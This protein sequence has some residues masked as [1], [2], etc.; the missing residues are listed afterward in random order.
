M[1]P[2]EIATMAKL[3]NVS[4]TVFLNTVF[5]SILETL[6]EKSRYQIEKIICDEIC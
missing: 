3:Y 1:T 2:K 5:V 4:I 6:N